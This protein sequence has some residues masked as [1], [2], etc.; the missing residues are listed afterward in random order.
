[1]EVAYNA[2]NY[3]RKRLCSTGLVLVECLVLLGQGSLTKR[4]GL[5]R[6]TSLF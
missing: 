4:K 1:M 6:L 3:D 2:V 5:V